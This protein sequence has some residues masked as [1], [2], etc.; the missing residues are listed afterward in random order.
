M[1]ESKAFDTVEKWKKFTVYE[2][3]HD[4]N[5]FVGLSSSC[6]AFLFKP[7]KTFFYS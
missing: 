2:N 6:A 5:F 7:T 4:F 3:I 1:A